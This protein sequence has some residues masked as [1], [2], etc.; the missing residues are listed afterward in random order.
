MATGKHK[1]TKSKKDPT[2]NKE[3]SG[4]SFAPH[5][6]YNCPDCGERLHDEDGNYY[7]PVCDDYKPA[8]WRK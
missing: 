2:Y 7:C 8:K 5:S 4:V 6:M 1:T 3:W